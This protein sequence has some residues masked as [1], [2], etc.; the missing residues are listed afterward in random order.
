[1]G[2]RREYKK[3][4]TV[5]SKGSNSVHIV[6]KENNS[7]KRKETIFSKIYHKLGKA[8]SIS[9]FALLVAII[10]GGG[11]LG[12]YQYKEN[13][14]I[15][16]HEDL[17]LYFERGTEEFEIENGKNYQVDYVNVTA[18]QAQQAIK[19]S[20]ADQVK[21][22]QKSLTAIES[23]LDMT[24]FVRNLGKLTAKNVVVRWTYYGDADFE[25]PLEMTNQH[26]I[27][28]FSDKYA[29]SIGVLEEIKKNQEYTVTF[30]AIS[31]DNEVGMPVFIPVKWSTNDSI[32]RNYGLGIQLMAENKK[33]IW[34]G[35]QI[36][37]FK[38]TEN[39]YWNYLKL[40]YGELKD[41]MKTKKFIIISDE[42]ET[43]IT[44]IVNGKIGKCYVFSKKK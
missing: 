44:R 21:T 38:M 35:L 2:R 24:F 26:Y 10:G 43:C 41:Y 30:P 32:I 36:S 27:R 25:V 14:R 37:E 28:G 33:T 18:I 31:P 39:D 29:G 6:S 1:M 9:L 12:Y 17:N 22:G 34:S 13:N 11:V 23:Y 20:K 40:N 7:A 42:N 19:I 5:V 16:Y 3:Q 4:K 8:V 15:N